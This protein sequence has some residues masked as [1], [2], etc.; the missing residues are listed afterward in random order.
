MGK[1]KIKLDLSGKDST[2]SGNINRY[3]HGFSQLDLLTSTNYLDPL[4]KGID[5]YQ[6]KLEGGA[7]GD[8]VEIAMRKKARKEVTEMFQKITYYIQSVA[9]EEDIPALVQAGFEVVRPSTR[10]KQVVAPA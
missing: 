8:R 10:R 9:T 2:F 5:Y 3:F 1:V 4:K 7:N 6:Q